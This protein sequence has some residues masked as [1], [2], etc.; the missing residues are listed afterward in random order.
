MGVIVGRYGF[1]ENLG[2]LSEGG[3]LFVSS[4]EDYEKYLFYFRSCGMWGVGGKNSRFLRRFWGRLVLV[5][6]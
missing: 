6:S 2:F 3:E 1:L 4:S 5:F